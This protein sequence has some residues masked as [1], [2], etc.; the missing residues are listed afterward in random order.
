MPKALYC[1]GNWV[2]P[3]PLPVRPGGIQA[4]LPTVGLSG[5]SVDTLQ[6]LPGRGTPP[7]E[8]SHQ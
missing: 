2:D 3:R 5:P 4:G 6:G 7:G 8:D 1:Q